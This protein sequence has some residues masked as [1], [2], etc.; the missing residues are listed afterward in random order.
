MTSFQTRHRFYV[1]EKLSK[2]TSQDFSI[3]GTTQSKFLATT[4]VADSVK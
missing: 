1:T 4:V 3:L 2:L